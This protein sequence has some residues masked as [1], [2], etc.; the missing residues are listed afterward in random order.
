[1]S[2][3]YG[4]N[5][6]MF[7]DQRVNFHAFEGNKNG[8]PKEHKFRVLPAY[9]PNK[10]FH[11]VGLHW[12]Y[13]AADGKQRALTC[14][15]ESHGSCPI[16]DKINFLKGQL[17]NIT[18]ALATDYDPQSRANLEQ[19]KKDTEEYVNTHKRKP[20]YLWNILTETGEQKVLQLSWNGHDP[21]H[22]KIKFIYS[23]QKI[24]VTSATSSALMYCNR[25]GLMAKTRYQYE[26]LAG[27]EKDI[28]GEVTTLTDLSKVYV[29]RSLEYLQQVVD[30]EMVPEDNINHNTRDIDAK[31][32]ANQPPQN[33]QVPLGNVNAQAVESAKNTDTIQ[34]TTNTS[35][36]TVSPSNPP[37]EQ[38]TVQQTVTNVTPVAQA[39]TQPQTNMETPV[40]TQPEINL[41]AEQDKSVAEMMA[42]LNS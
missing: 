39:Q 30:T 17:E 27:F 6:E 1:M 2:L 15:L 20:M 18:A 37:V 23:Q 26:M 35:A 11:K 7:N 31:P 42:A 10:L 8:S 19:Q 40:H 34:S 14:T 9:A 24:D 5:D 32:V 25:S 22:E 12:G 16:C 38:N 4:L 29:P 36:Q 3:G 41:T 21:L 28:T 33:A 13:K